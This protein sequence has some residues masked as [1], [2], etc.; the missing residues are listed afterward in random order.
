[1]S[2]DVVKL[3]NSSSMSI[4]KRLTLLAL[5]A[6]LGILVLTATFLFS[7]KKLIMEERQNNVR[8]VVE[9]A[10]G[11]LAS[12]HGLALKG[13]MSQEEAK[14]SALAELATMRY[15]GNEYFWVN[16]MQPRMIM[17]PINAAL[18]GKDLT[19]NKD[20]TGKHLFVEF[21]N[22]VKA[23][24]E[25]FVPYLWPKPG[26]AEPVQ[27]VSY[28]KG[29]APWGWIIGSG[30]YVDTVEAAIMGRFLTFVIGAFLLGGV[31]LG[32]C[33][34]ISRGLLK[35]LG[36]EPA[37]AMA[38]MGRI[39]QGD[40]K[41]SITLKRNDQS[42]L[43]YEIKAMRDSIAR[44]VSQVRVGTDAIVTASAEIAAGNQDL[45]SRTEQQASSLEETA[46]TMEQITSTVKQNADNARQ[47]NQLATSASGFAVKG[48]EVVAQVVGTMSSINESSKRIVDIISVI[49]GIAF[50]TNILALNAAVEAARAGEQGRGFAVVASE[51]RNLAQRSASAAKEIKT[52]I[53]DSVDKVDTGSKLVN[54]AGVTMQEIVESVHKVTDI[55]AEITAASQEQSS[56]IEQVNQ[57]I[58]Q[59]DQV[60]QQNAA[61]V[62]EAA[63]A[64]ESM[65]D[66]ASSLAQVVTLF[67][68][69]DSQ[70]LAQSA[71]PSVR[72]AASPMQLQRL[73]PAA[74]KMAGK[75]AGK[76]ANKAPL[77]ASDWEEF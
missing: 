37:Y 27:K 34:V 4:A 57:A 35:Q 48:G 73:V 16:D 41:G 18:I 74:K 65:Q 19:D 40:L 14:Q 60:T 49:D 77:A 66:Q 12:Y 62:E 32:I 43:L 31:L 63:A 2:T 47:A 17:H 75:G 15:S 61:L 36:A 8:Q 7:E 71:A 26:S 52:L 38:I 54:E 11:V 53:G 50:Q 70:A 33:L 55:M 30:V 39:A 76:L 13:K 68:I 67:K 72:A 20:P 59:M 69:D 58:G 64:A 45:S 22:M 9:T 1:M 21:V 10:Y 51:V 24:G 3:Q 46:S 29:F 5:S 44:I 56:G 25:G 28:V 23:N 6:L 42:S